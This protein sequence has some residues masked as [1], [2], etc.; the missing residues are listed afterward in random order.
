MNTLFKNI[1]RQLIINLLFAF[2]WV[3]MLA[4]K[5]DKAIQ[6]NTK[7]MIFSSIC[8]LFLALNVFGIIKAIRESKAKN[9]TSNPS[10]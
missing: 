6:G 10:N 2:F 5:Y 3:W 9:N 8:L 1:S 4:E 7:S